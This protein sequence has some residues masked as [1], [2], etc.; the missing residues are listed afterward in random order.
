M[1]PAIIAAI[2]AGATAL[3]SAGI[4]ASSNKKSKDAATAS[5][6]QMQ[7]QYDFYNKLTAQ[8]ETQRNIA[9]NKW[10]SL[11]TN[12]QAYRTP[13]SVGKYVDLMQQLG[14]EL[15]QLRDPSNKTGFDASAYNSTIDNYAMARPNGEIPLQGDVLDPKSADPH[16]RYGEYGTGKREDSGSSVRIRPKQRKSGDVPPTDQYRR[17]N[18]ESGGVPVRIGGNN[19]NL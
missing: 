16:G 15:S 18:G 11:L 12:Q 8:R 17:P 19:L 7:Q 6:Q 14:G 4:S 1:A 13:G 3:G 2:I 5:G 10:Q 9:M